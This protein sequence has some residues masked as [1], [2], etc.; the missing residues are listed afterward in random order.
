MTFRFRSPQS[1]SVFI[2]F[3]GVNVTQMFKIQ[4][5]RK[6]DSSSGDDK[7]QGYYGR[8]WVTDARTRGR[9][10][11]SGGF[12]PTPVS[13]VWG[14]K[15]TTGGVGGRRR[16]QTSCSRATS[17]FVELPPAPSVRRCHCLQTMHC[18]RSDS[19]CLQNKSALTWK[20]F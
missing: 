11:G 1:A 10:I 17:E 16:R 15:T 5:K 4:K 20:T 3:G 7:N 2:H 12:P 14:I 6:D 9:W 18:C 13:K 8:L 19:L